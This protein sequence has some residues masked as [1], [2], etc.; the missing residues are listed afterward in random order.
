MTEMYFQLVFN[1]RSTCDDKINAV[2]LVPNSQLLAVK[3]LL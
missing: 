1:Q 2:R 3:A